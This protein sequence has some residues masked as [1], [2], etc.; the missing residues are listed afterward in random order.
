M[1][2]VDNRPFLKRLKY[3]L[4]YRLVKGLIFIA[5]KLPRAV[6]YFVYGGLGSI[7]YYFAGKS[8]DKAI[9]NLTIVF[10]KEKTQDEIKG[11]AK[12]MFLNLGKNL[13][14]VMRVFP[15]ENLDQLYKQVQI[16]GKENLDVAYAKGKGVVLLTAHIGAFEILGTFIGLN[17]KSIM[18][19]TKLKD[20]R[21]DALKVASRSK[22]GSKYV[23]RGENTLQ[24]MRSLKEGRVMIILI[25]QDTKVKSRFVEFMGVPA[26][27]PVGAT[28]IALKTGADIVPVV[29]QM[30][31]F[32]NQT[33]TCMPALEITRSSDAEQDLLDNTLR[34]NQAIDA[35]I[36]KDPSQWVWMHDRFK[37][38]PG[39]EII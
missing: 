2:E 1:K 7:A 32:D 19:G 39:Q 27:T 34:M 10:G 12:K 15:M 8:R 24:L 26:A 31:A 21:L 25:D 36:R 4:L 28:M 11:I 18:V 16:I 14:T 30:D 33:I 38:K 13:A 6:V 3:T 23:H 29:V 9:E 35:F 20:P 37:T 22:G 17:Y 5:E